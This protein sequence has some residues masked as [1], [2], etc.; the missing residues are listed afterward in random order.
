MA[1][2]IKQL[3]RIREVA[4]MLDVST[5]AL[6]YWESEFSRLNPK[7]SCNGQ[8]RYTPQ[9]VRVCRQIRELLY[10]KGVKIEKAKEI[11]D[12]PKGKSGLSGENVCLDATQ[13]L[14][15]LDEV[16]ETTNR[17]A[18]KDKIKAVYDWISNLD[19]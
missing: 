19:R 7:R 2:M 15:L 10:E 5:S 9:N 13:A 16:L 8:R 4:E 14:S 18:V 1:Q 3:Y 17:Q 11:I 6:R 12:S